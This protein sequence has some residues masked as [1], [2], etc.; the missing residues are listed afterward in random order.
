MTAKDMRKHYDALYRDDHRYWGDAPSPL[1]LLLLPH[2]K[3]RANGKRLLDIGCGQGPDTLFFAKKGFHV[4]AMDI[5][6][7]AIDDLR[8][9]AK[10]A[11][12]DE[13][14]D[15]RVADMLE[16][17]QERFDVIF[18]RMALQMIP[19]ERRIEYIKGLK[20]RYPDALH[21]HIIPITGACFGDEFICDDALL[22]TGYAGWNIILHDT[23]WTVSRVPNKN[24]EH[25]LMRE[26]RI[27]ARR[28]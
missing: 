10:D 18:S 19:V 28:I 27:L 16:P 2:I 26:A 17:P 25:Y 6:P 12:I 9:H 13:R 5:S 20:T 22:T 3:G 1:S 7:I 4:I 24:G 23:V 15:A 21:A 14:I 8:R 11:G